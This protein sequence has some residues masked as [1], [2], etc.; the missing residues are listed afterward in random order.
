MNSQAKKIDPVDLSAPSN[1]HVI[2]RNRRE[3]GPTNPVLGDGENDELQRFQKIA[4]IY[5]RHNYIKNQIELTKQELQEDMV[6]VRR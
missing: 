4:N 5:E 6:Q 2:N 1:F 3:S